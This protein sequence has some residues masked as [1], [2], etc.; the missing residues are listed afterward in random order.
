MTNATSGDNWIKACILQASDASPDVSPHA[1]T[2][3]EG[4][5]TGSFLEQRLPAK[6]LAEIADTLLVEAQPGK[7]E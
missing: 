1:V 7:P 6:K 4:L 2:L 5:L 3:I